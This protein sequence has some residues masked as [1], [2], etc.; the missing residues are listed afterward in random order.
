MSKIL[1]LDVIV[2]VM[3][4]ASPVEF[5]PIGCARNCTLTSNANIAGKSTIGSGIYQEFIGLSI[6]WDVSVD[7]LATFNENTSLLTLRQLQA[8]LQPVVISFT[9]TVGDSSVEYTGNAL[10]TSV[11]ASGNY[12]DAETFDVQFQG[13][14]ELAADTGTIFGNPPT[15]LE[16][17]SFTIGIPEVGDTELIVEWNVAFPVPAGG[18]RIKIHNVLS[19]ED[20]YQDVPVGESVDVVVNDSSPTWELSIKSVYIAGLLESEYSPTITYP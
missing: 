16:I 18:Y 8:A 7:G 6:N 14:G 19:D 17:T 1:G 20:T 15:G 13:T 11:V 9:E 2:K 5:E 4:S 3:V 10:I 12:A